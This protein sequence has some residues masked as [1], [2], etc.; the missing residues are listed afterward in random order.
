LRHGCIGGSD[1]GGQ[2]PPAAS[3][4]PKDKL[5][6]HMGLAG[7]QKQPVGNIGTAI[8]KLL[9]PRFI[10]TP[11]GNTPTGGRW[12]A[13]QAVHPQACGEHGDIQRIKGSLVGSSPRLWGTL[14]K[15]LAVDK[16][17]RFIP[18]P[19]GNTKAICSYRPLFLKHFPYSPSEYFLYF[20]SL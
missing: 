5:L 17:C 11:V 4:N 20:P 8:C 16:A 1:S 18:T 13:Q 14:V 6:R 3:G 19:V 9:C 12:T 10:P 2:P 7:P 15:R